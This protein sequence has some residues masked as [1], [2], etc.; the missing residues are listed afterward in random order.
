MPEALVPTKN[1]ISDDLR[2]LRELTL[3][4]DLGVGALEERVRALLVYAGLGALDAEA[5]E[6]DA[7]TI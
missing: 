2:K 3:E 5:F 1:S 6:A 4:L 7:E